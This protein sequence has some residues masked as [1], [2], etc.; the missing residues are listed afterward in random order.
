[1]IVVHLTSENDSIANSVLLLILEPLSRHIKTR[2]AATTN[3]EWEKTPLGK[4]LP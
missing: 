1:M 3:E 2:L 4:T